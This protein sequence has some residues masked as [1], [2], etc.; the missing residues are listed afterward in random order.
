MA[1]LVNA[2]WSTL[3][4]KRPA[5]PARERGHKCRGLIVLHVNA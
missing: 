1:V 4:A 2:T 5:R 3:A